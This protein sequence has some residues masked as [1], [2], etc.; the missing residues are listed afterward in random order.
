MND[1][2]YASR[3][4][5]K[6]IEATVVTPAGDASSNLRGGCKGYCKASGQDDHANHSGGR[7]ASGSGISTLLLWWS[8]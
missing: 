3:Q 6:P 1:V 8:S 7:A 2:S 4:P 5:G